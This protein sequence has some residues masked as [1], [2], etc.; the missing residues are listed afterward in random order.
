M[1]LPVFS[2]HASSYSGYTPTLT[3]IAIGVYGLTQALFQ[4]PL[5]MLSDR[6]GR[7]RIILAGLLVFAVWAWLYLLEWSWGVGGMGI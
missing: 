2:L 7:R 4:I 3:G 6:F 1:V 5:G